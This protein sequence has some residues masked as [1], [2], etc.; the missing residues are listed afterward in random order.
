[1]PKVPKKTNRVHNQGLCRL[2]CRLPFWYVRSR[3]ARIERNFS[4]RPSFSRPGVQLYP[5]QTALLLK[6][7]FPHYSAPSAAMQGIND[8][9]MNLHPTLTVHGFMVNTTVMTYCMY[10]QYD[11]TVCAV[12]AGVF[13]ACG[14]NFL[15][16]RAP[17]YQNRIRL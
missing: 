6:L 9:Y 4:C 2:G 13:S 14:L 15:N 11:T 1:M 16:T 17:E 12:C 8:P 5:A 7:S 3:G 10:V